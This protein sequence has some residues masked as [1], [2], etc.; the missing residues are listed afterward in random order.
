MHIYALHLKLALSHARRYST[1]TFRD[2]TFHGFLHSNTSFERY[3][4][5]DM[6]RRLL[7]LPRRPGALRVQLQRVREG[8]RLRMATA[9]HSCILIFLQTKAV[10]DA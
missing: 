8:D 3:V 4:P 7:V 1:E 5:F 10:C 2:G 9:I 6:C